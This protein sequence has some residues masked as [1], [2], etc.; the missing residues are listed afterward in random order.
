MV[1]W[2]TVRDEEAPSAVTPSARFA[3][4]FPIK[5]KEEKP[6]YW[7]SSVG[8]LSSAT[9]AGSPGMA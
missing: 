4:T 3:G 9:S 1:E 5:G 8:G 7:S 6:D 2:V